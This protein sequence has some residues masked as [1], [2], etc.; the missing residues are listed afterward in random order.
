MAM[1]PSFKF[2]FHSA[3]DSISDIKVP[4]FSSEKVGRFKWLIIIIVCNTGISQGPVI[5]S[6]LEVFPF[7]F[8]IILRDLQ[9][10]PHVLGQA[11]RQW[12]EMLTSS[13]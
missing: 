3:Q 10:M 7:P 9:K 8:Y 2:L 12:L 5:A 13:S 6:Y 4:M 1:D 11:L